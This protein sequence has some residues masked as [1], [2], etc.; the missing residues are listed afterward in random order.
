[1]F[2]AKQGNLLMFATLM[3]VFF[4]V[5]INL[6]DKQNGFRY[7]W[8]LSDNVEKQRLLN[9]DLSDYNNKLHKEIKRLAYSSA[10]LENQARIKLGMVKVNELFY[11][12]S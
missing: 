3:A 4:V 9:Q 1:L 5:Q 2:L 12:Y 10:V 11:V 7:G 8:F 6:W